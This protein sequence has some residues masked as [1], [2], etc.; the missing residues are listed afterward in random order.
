M[1]LRK[2]FA[3][4]LA[5]TSLVLAEYNSMLFTKCPQAA[6]AQ[7]PVC[8][9][10]EVDSMEK[11]TVKEMGRYF[12]QRL[13]SSSDCFSRPDGRNPLAPP[14]CASPRASC[15]PPPVCPAAEAPVCPVQA[16]TCPPAPP[17]PCADRPVPAARPSLGQQAPPPYPAD[18][19]PSVTVAKA[20]ESSPVLETR[21][22][23]KVT[24]SASDRV[25]IKRELEN[26]AE[27]VRDL[28]A[29]SSNLTNDIEQAKNATQTA[30]D[31]LRRLLSRSMDSGNATSA[32]DR[33]DNASSS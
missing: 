9:T 3:R 12:Q 15:A 2:R 24:E 10:E 22:P 6:P 7:Q 8:P 30:I 21:I 23:D 33:V 32:V 1:D 17:L 4:D 26:I 11:Y 14:P 20:P 28:S 5:K 18:N 19:C 16:Q 13:K 31:D 27:S 25:N 29:E